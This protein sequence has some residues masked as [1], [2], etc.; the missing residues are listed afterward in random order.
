MAVSSWDVLV[1]NG[2]YERERERERERYRRIDIE[3][4]GCLSLV[5]TSSF[6]MAGI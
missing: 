2:G 4:Q 6:W 5:V 3:M 1:L